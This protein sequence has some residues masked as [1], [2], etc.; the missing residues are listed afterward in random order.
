MSEDQNPSPPESLPPANTA[1]PHPLQD[2]RAE[3]K[4]ENAFLNLVFNIVIPIAI[5]NKGTEPLGPLKALLVALA[6]PIFYGI[7]D[8]LRRKKV[9]AFSI[10]GLLNVSLTGGLAL[11]GLGGTWF[12]IKEAVFPLVIGL[13]VAG[14]G[15]TKRPLIQTL[16]VNPQSM[17]WDLIESRLQELGREDE[18]LTL[19]RRSTW[20]LAGSFLVSAILNFVLAQRVFLPIDPTLPDLEHAKVL[21]EQIAQMTGLSFM[22]IMVPSMVMLIGIMT[23]LFRGM[24]K[25]TG[26]SLQDMMK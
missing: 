19:L 15:F 26:L 18:F 5:L 17:K 24:T 11:S 12:A 1:P 8:L 4:G 23:Y 16:V 2:T 3:A 7:Y 21:N 10:V 9:N 14:S 20:L 13:F 25:T 22:V 6:F